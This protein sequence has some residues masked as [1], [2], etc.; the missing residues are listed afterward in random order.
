MIGYSSRGLILQKKK[1]NKSKPKWLQGFGVV[2]SADEHC[3]SKEGAPQRINREHLYI[4]SA[5]LANAIQDLELGEGPL[6]HEARLWIM[7][8]INSMPGF[9][10]ADICQ[11]FNIS[12]DAARN[13]IL[14][15]FS[16][17]NHEHIYAR[18]MR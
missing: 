12:I 8:E 6:F 5:V 2:F 1:K 10:F 9:S 17:R 13:T 4:R 14:S 7:G 15:R 18:G 3:L 16:G 11:T